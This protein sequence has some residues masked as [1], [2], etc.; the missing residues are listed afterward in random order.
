MRDL[1]EAWANEGP[2]VGDA[3]V[4]EPPPAGFA[5]ASP[6]VRTHCLRHDTHSARD[7]VPTDEVS[8]LLRAGWRLVLSDEDFLELVHLQAWYFQV[9]HFPG[10]RWFVLGPPPGGN[11]VIADRPVTMAGAGAE[12]RSM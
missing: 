6:V 12:S 10:L 5:E 8:S 3:P 7:V 1:C 2:A 4:V 9:R 11:F